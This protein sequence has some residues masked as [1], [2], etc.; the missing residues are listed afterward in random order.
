MRTPRWLRNLSLG[1]S[2][3]GLSLL[4]TGCLDVLQTVERRGDTVE[5]SI[6]I[7]FSKSLIEGGA[8]MSGEEPDYSDLPEFTGE[9]G[10]V[11]ITIPG[12]RVETTSINSETDIGAQVVASYPARIVSTAPEEERYFLPV[13]AGNTL[14]IVLPPNEDAAEMDQMTSMF[15]GGSRYRLLV[16]EAGRAV[17][18]V[19]VN[20]ADNI[21]TVTRVGG[22]SYIEI[23]LDIWMLSSEPMRVKVQF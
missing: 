6:R 23:P 18:S 16:D 4:L 8:A 15:F 17:R 10:I 5:T 14:D 20:G 13:Y 1:L 19:L 12:V 7:T 9:D 2:V 11:D 22:V 3:V 21:A